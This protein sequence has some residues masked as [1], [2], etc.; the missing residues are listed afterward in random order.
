MQD[1]TLYQTKFPL[2]SVPINSSW[3]KPMRYWQGP[4]WININWLLI[5]GLE[6]YGYKQLASELSEQTINLVKNS[7]FNEYFNPIDG[8]AAGVH[9]FSWTAALIID[10]LAKTK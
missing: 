6:R 2:P 8:S 7:G 4:T 1:K 3:F 5:D 10:L 9:D